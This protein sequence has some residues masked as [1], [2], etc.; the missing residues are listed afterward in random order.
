M[1]LD[2][3]K[4]YLSVTLA[5]LILLSA[6][7]TQAFA[8]VY[9]PGTPGDDEGTVGLEE[10]VLD[11]SK[12]TVQLLWLEGDGSGSVSSDHST[13]YLTATG[14]ET[15]Q[16]VSKAILTNKSE[17]TAKLAFDYS[18]TSFSSFAIGGE[19][20]SNGEGEY[21]VVLEP[22]QTVT[23]TITGAEAAYGDAALTLDNFALTPIATDATVTVIY[24]PELGSVTLGADV[25]A[26]GDGKIVA[27]KV[28]TDGIGMVAEPAEGFNFD[29][30]VIDSTDELLSSEQEYT[31]VPT[32]DIT[33]RAV[34]STPRQPAT[35][36]VGSTVYDNL[37]AAVTAAQSH[38]SKTVILN[39]SGV[40][41]EGVYNIPSGV[42]LTIPFGS[43]DT[44]TF[45]TKPE[46]ATTQYTLARSAFRTLILEDGAILNIEGQLNVNGRVMKAAGN[47]TGVCTGDYGC[48]DL[49]GNSA[50]NL[51]GSGKLYCY[52]YIIGDGTVTA[53]S[54]TTVHEVF[55]MNGWRGGSVTLGWQNAANIESFAF[56]DYSVQNVEAKLVVKSG[57]TANVS[58]TVSGNV[59]IGIAQW[60][61]TECVSTT[62]IGTIASEKGFI[63]LGDGGAV[64]RTY[65]AD[66]NRAEFI[67]DGEVDIES[68]N[69]TINV[70]KEY[71]L[72]TAEYIMAIPFGMDFVA[73]TGSKVTLNNSFKLLPGATL[74]AKTGSDIFVNGQLYIYDT[75]DYRGKGP[76]T[77]PVAYVASTGQ[78]A[79][80]LP[81]INSRTPSGLVAVNGTLTITDKGAMYTT[82]NGGS[83]V[84][85]VLQ[86]NGKIINNSTANA[87]LTNVLD[88]FNNSLTDNNIRVVPVVGQI[89]GISVGDGY[90]SFANEGA[91]YYGTG[92]GYW[93]QHAVSV[94]A[95]ENIRN[96][97]N[98]SEAVT[99]GVSRN[100]TLTQNGTEISNVIGFISDYLQIDETVN[101]ETGEVTSVTSTVVTTPF[102]FTVPVRTVV[103]AD[104]GTLEGN[105]SDATPY[106]LTVEN[107][108]TV[109]TVASKVAGEGELLMRYDDHLDISQYGENVE[110]INAGSPIS[111]K[112]GYGVEENTEY[113]NAVIAIEGNYLVATGIGTATVRLGDKEYT[114][115]VIAAPISMLF[116][117]GQSN[118]QGSRG[119]GN[120]SIVC[121]EGMVYGTYGDR[122]SMTASNATQYAPSSLT[123]P[124]SLINVIGG[125][126]K[127][128]DYPVMMHN[129]GV[130]TKD[131]LGKDGPDSGFA[132]QWVQSTGEKVWVINA[133]HGG[134][135]LAEWVKGGT[136]YNEAVALFKACQE[137]LQKE[138]AAG[139]YTLS[140]M[141]FYWCQGE[142]DSTRSAEYYATNF[143]SM[144]ENLKADLSADMDSNSNTPDQT[145]EFTN[146]ILTFAGSL[147][148][149]GYRYDAEEGLYVSG[150]NKGWRTYEEL[151][152]RGQRVA[153]LWLGANPAY[154]D[155]NVVCNIA[156]GWYT[157]PENTELPI[158]TLSVKDYF[159][160]HYAGGVIDYPT[161]TEQSA[162]WRTPDGPEDVRCTA[163]DGAGRL[164]YNQLGYNE[165]GREAVRNTMILLGYAQ[166]P[167]VATKVKFYDWTGYREVESITAATEGQSST[168]VV[169]VVAPIYRAKDVTYTFGGN[170]NYNYYDLIADAKAIEGTLK[171]IGANT[172]SV[173]VVGRELGEY[174]WDF[175]DGKFESTGTVENIPHYKSGSV[176][177]GAFNNILYT[178]DD[179]VV[180]QQDENWLVEIKM[181]NTWEKTV[182][183]VLANNSGARMAGDVAIAA[184]ATGLVFSYVYEDGGSHT[185]HGISDVMT[186]EDT[187]PHIFRM[188]NKVNAATGKNQVYFSIDGGASVAMDSYVNGQSY[189]IASIGNSEYP[190]TGGSIEYIYIKETG[191]TGDLH[192]HQWGEW[193]Q[194]T[195]PTYLVP[196]IKER[197]CACGEKETAE[198]PFVPYTSY[199]WDL[200]DGVM[201]ST[202]S[203]DNPLTPQGT[204]SI[205]L[206]TG[207]FSN[208]QYTMQIPIQ[209]KQDQEWT[210]EFEMINTWTS[211]KIV[212]FLTTNLGQA[213][214][215]VSLGFGT[216]SVTISTVKSN[217]TSHD[218]AGAAIGITRSAEDTTPHKI[219]IYNV[220]DEETNTN[221]LWVSVGDGEPVAF[222]AGANGRDYTFGCIGSS[223]YPLT[224]GSI[225]YL[226]VK[227]SGV[228]C[229][230][231]YDEGVVTREPTCAEEGVTTF[232]CS[233]CGGIKTEAIAKLDHTY[234]TTPEWIWTGSNTT[235]YTAATANFACECGEKYTV[236]AEVEEKVTVE[237]TETTEGS[238]VYT[239]TA[240]YNETSYT[241]TKTVVLP[242]LGEAILYDKH[243]WE[244]NAEKNELVSVKTNGYI[245]N[246][247]IKK[248]GTITDGVT[249]NLQYQF[250]MPVV[251]DH[252]KSWTIEWD[253][254]R[255]T[256]ASWQKILAGQEKALSGT[257]NCLMVMST[258]TIALSYYTTSK[259][260]NNYSSSAMATSDF[261]IEDQHTYK[262]ENRVNEDG[263]NTIYLWVDKKPIGTFDTH[264]TADKT[265]W[266][267]S[268]DLTFKYIGQQA[269][270][271]GTKYYGLTGATINYIEVQMEHTH[272]WNETPAWTWTGDDTNGYTAATATFSC[273]CG[274]EQI[275]DAVITDEVT[276][277]PTET[278]EGTRIYTTTVVFNEKTYIDQKTVTIEKE[279]VHTGTWYRWQLNDSKD[280]LVSATTNGYTE[281][282]L[283]NKVGT[284]S[285]GVTNKLQYKFT[286]PVVL[287]YTKP[288]SVEWKMTGSI[289]T[290]QKILV[291]TQNNGTKN[292]FCLMVTGEKNVTLSKF[293]N[294]TH[295]NYKAGELTD[296]DINMKTGTYKYRLENVYNENGTNTIYLYI[297]DVL[298]GAMDDIA[299]G[300][301]EWINN[302]TITFNYIGTQN[303][304][305]LNG[306]T[307]DYI[308]VYL[309]D[310]PA[311]NEDHTHS[312]GA[313][314]FIWNTE[315][316]PATCTATFTCSVCNEGTEGHEL[317][318]DCVVT[319]KNR[320]DATCSA[321]GSVIYT[322][323]ATVEFGDKTYTDDS[324]TVVIPATG[325]HS[326]GEPGYEWTGSDADGYTVTATAVC[327][328][329]YTVTETVTATYAVTTEPTETTTGI[330][331]YT[332]IFENELFETQTD[333]VEI[334]V[335]GSEEETGTTVSGTAVSWNGSDDTVYLLY[336]SSSDDAAIK[337]EWAAEN[338][339]YTA[340]YTATKGDITETTVDSKSMKSQSFTFEGVAEGTYKL[341]ILKP[342]KY[343]PK[344]VEITVG[345]EAVDV[346]QQKLWLCGDVNYDGLI[347]SNDATQINRYFNNKASIFDSG[348]TQTKID[349]LAAADVN[350]DGSILSNDATQI[351]R[352]FN[353]KSSVFDLLK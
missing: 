160:K 68:I 210:V 184:T 107:G 154:P 134:S 221:Q 30:W 269:N 162:S 122:Y 65:H 230:H 213:A 175:A 198:V 309:G 101:E 329:G 274:D 3:L 185:N 51:S 50:I 351:N 80:T 307:I 265:A 312:Y 87:P 114:V 292:D 128:S 6:I 85:K 334:P 344:I 97:K 173:S 191:A 98:L 10:Y 353:N 341:V 342:G 245:E 56:N 337:A 264:D 145:I 261:N 37:N 258:R 126:S 47:Y 199:R 333:T 284:I 147:S 33:I 299:S 254:S 202:G 137:T 135:A 111:Y 288:W 35:F 90:H 60:L 324:E 194:V 201:V 63:R 157:M 352:Y 45:G 335:T 36:K 83:S 54:G 138:I 208:V 306:A 246:A 57:A 193:K 24:N 112:V 231:T 119:N 226:E 177:N 132:Y 218:N 139:H 18:A 40:L 250:T 270:S 267:P 282:A 349:R 285:D 336:S 225:R 161:Q 100:R 21:A 300:Y 41:A 348:D 303:K 249:D 94:D 17:S 325:E 61:Q 77:K 330:G 243:R 25:D 4:R 338:P 227:E 9:E 196:G 327:S 59:D 216:N 209:L 89:A 244:L 109:L 144:Y 127:L 340:L 28:G 273:E 86:G 141:G 212:K 236:E 283:T 58:A 293:F 272:V 150:D 197:E 91:T 205:N 43:D 247:L 203:I 34:F 242:A 319:E 66:T 331:T 301:T 289:D 224:G 248:S 74:T 263:T 190:L 153:Q 276:V 71:S 13:I 207:I 136:Q 181:V 48:I 313:P 187:T 29:G 7:P 279:T 232:T 252:T 42:K 281:N 165:M 332:A 104:N 158:G 206:E 328:C 237:P 178:L 102:T 1:L 304:Y 62:Y 106:A 298:I 217:G 233:I 117:G 315:G 46:T 235:G 339:E 82:E 257:E 321:D 167:A 23:V 73:N 287:D 116:L 229:D 275:V 108:N 291:A 133:A 44:G 238:K 253:M 251:L 38:Y 27:E 192:I 220:V 131:G 228:D 268:A 96:I 189:T 163:T 260:H 2:R 120:Q 78:M 152:M 286:T 255:G 320:T 308:E 323:T 302:A 93:Y 118:M 174:R 22:E 195:D 64:S 69:L 211:T 31:H 345:S 8:A 72:N 223:N 241:D 15:T 12:I 347:A 148:S 271:A 296:S 113:D 11:E 343:V 129:A 39:A 92:D 171:A 183:K 67:F 5:V 99:A 266:L 326:Y 75:A 103:E 278:T 310:A 123:G 262:L 84:D 200:L 290:W 95:F 149:T 170:L 239:A 52:G 166:N 130:A 277:E 124:N 176:Q 234:G 314:E 121:L 20:I 295:N 105:G 346:G 125:T 79:A 146:I 180:L 305:Q 14:G 32:E 159:A 215:D 188:F 214:G 151:E 172:A 26:D 318:V 115:D 222:A 16:C 311:E 316:Y 88:E 143:L 256:N 179:P 259:S 70:V 110:I 49:E 156:D 297:E 164:H 81:K 142:S 240:T 169:P 53:N 186:A 168:L 204:G 182:T 322:A 155:I 19:S 317:T 350:I 55:Q 140:H 219:K 280:E 76:S 294:G